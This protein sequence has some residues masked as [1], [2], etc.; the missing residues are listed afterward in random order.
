MLKAYKRYSTDKLFF[1]YSVEIQWCMTIFSLMGPFLRTDSQ[2]IEIT[3]QAQ[4]S[5]S[6]CADFHP[7]KY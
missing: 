2:N 7:I 3:T 4:K 5:L 1:Y 6:E